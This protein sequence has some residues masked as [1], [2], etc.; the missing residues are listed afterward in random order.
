MAEKTDIDSATYVPTE[1]V[2]PKTSALSI[3]PEDVDF[4]TEDVDAPCRQGYIYVI[5]ESVNGRATGFYK[6]GRTGNPDKRLSD[7]QTGN[8]RPLGFTRTVEVT[9]VVPCGSCRS[10]CTGNLFSDYVRWRNRVVSRK[11]SART[12]ILPK[13]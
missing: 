11:R 7:L 8:V 5:C 3:Y 1:K 12:S 6:V 10:Q 2:L 4:G 9:D 13:L